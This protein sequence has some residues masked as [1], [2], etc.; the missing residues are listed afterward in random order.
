M[1]TRQR[2]IHCED[3]PH[4][5]APCAM[6]LRLLAALAHAVEA[7]APLSGPDF[8]LSGQIQLTDC[9]RTCRLNWVASAGECRLFVNT[10]PEANSLPPV[11]LARMQAVVLQ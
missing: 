7:A 3:C 9:G 11:T 4:T 5:G 8:S 2:L 6:G 10:D 1:L